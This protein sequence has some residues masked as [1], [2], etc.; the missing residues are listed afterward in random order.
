MTLN[1]LF[2]LLLS[3]LGIG[4]I[5]Y[6]LVCLA[7]LLG[8]NRLIFLPIAKLEKT[9]AEIGLEYE[10]VWIGVRTWTGK[11]ERVHGWWIPGARG[12]RQV[13]LYL[14]GNGGNISYNLAPVQA[15]HRLGFSTLVFDYRGYGRS[16]GAF[17][18][19]SEV[20]RDAGAVWDYLVKIR[21]IEPENIFLYGHSL[22]GAVAI[23]LAVRQPRAAGVITDGTFTSLR[24]I[25]DRIP[26][27]RF[28]PAD[29]LLT[30]HFDSLS[31]LRILRVPLLLIHGTEDRSVPVT[32]SQVLYDKAN[33]PK[34]LLIVEGAGHNDLISIAGKTYLDT[35]ESFT[36]TARSLPRSHAKS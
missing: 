2:K 6:F 21:G 23:D 5:A 34:Q 25:I 12:D 22:G 9:P 11:T 13:M 4:L 19:E 29:L 28:F 27:Y 33:V 1:L 14:H 7:I 8:Q 15:F 20:Y 36:R 17:P 3:G 24:A 10:E 16:E 31:K 26:V 30:H 32:M 35:L 18:T